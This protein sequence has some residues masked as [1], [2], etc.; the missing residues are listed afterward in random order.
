MRKLRVTVVCI[1]LTAMIFAY[2]MGAFGAPLAL[3][4]D[5]V[6]SLKISMMPGAGFPVDFTLTGYITADTL[7]GGFVALGDREL[8]IYSSHGNLLRRIPHGYAR[9]CMTAGSSRVCIYSRGDTELTVESRTRNLVTRTFDNPI[10]LAEMSENGMLAVFTKNQLE[11]FDPL[12]ESIWTW[13]NVSELPLAMAFGDDNKKLAVAS[14]SASGGAIGTTLHFFSTRSEKEQA[15]VTVPD[16]VPVKMQYRGGRL[17][18]IY[19]SF[20]ALYSASG[21]EVARYDYGV[22]QLQSASVDS[23][24][25]TALLFGAQHYPG[26][27]GFVTLDASLTEMGTASV[28]SNVNS[29]AMADKT[30]YILANGAVLHY[31]LTGELIEKLPMDTKPL[32]VL[33]AKD[34]LLVTAK[35]VSALK[36][37]RAAAT[38]ASSASGAQ[39][40]SDTGQAAE[41]PDASQSV[42]SDAAA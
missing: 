9:P 3:M 33:D 30:V 17:L 21:Q 20:A 39:Q 23:A 28:R 18:V 8:M 41:P 24:G 35:S 1:V 37:R 16:G 40:G 29:I 13:N 22:R 27:T 36:I 25:R 19:D 5:M 7:S 31:A 12:F 14:L 38:G 10:L 2:F 42:A 15:T 11:V 4:G 6:D 26:I 34:P 32:A